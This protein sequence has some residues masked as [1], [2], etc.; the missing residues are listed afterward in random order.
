MGTNKFGRFYGTNGHTWRKRAVKDFEGKIVII[1]AYPQIYRMLIGKTGRKSPV[2][3]KSYDKVFDVR[4][5]KLHI[6]V[7]YNFTCQLISRKI[8]PF[9]VFDGGVPEEK[10]ECI[11]KRDETKRR[12]QKK[13]ES[14]EDENSE[15]AIKQRKKCIKITPD[16]VKDCVEMLQLMGIGYVIA[17]KESDEQ[18]V[19]IYNYFTNPANKYTYVDDVGVTH[20]LDLSNTMAGIVSNDTDI[21]TFGGNKLLKDFSLT[22][23]FTDEITMSDIITVLQN[24]S[25]VI[26]SSNSKPNLRIRLDDFVNFSIL[27]GTNYCQH[28]D[29]NFSHNDVNELYELF[30]LNELNVE[31]T[32]RTIYEQ[33]TRSKNSSI[34]ESDV[35]EITTEIAIQKFM[36]N[37]NKTLR[38]YKTTKVYNP[39]NIDILPRYSRHNIEQLKNLIISCKYHVT[40][41]TDNIEEHDDYTK[42]VSSV[43]R[44][45][46]SVT[47]EIRAFL[48]RVVG[49]TDPKFC[50]FGTYR[51][52][53]YRGKA[54]REIEERSHNECSSY[55]SS[56]TKKRIAYT[57]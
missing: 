29:S 7:L 42:F 38:L 6:Y 34:V 17:P 2:N 49:P 53:Y 39:K 44:Q 19:A 27:M 54:E 57:T 18:L 9:Y 47:T 22:D 21:L 13:L 50:N 11:A 25:N 55:F 36:D 26:T 56:S 43:E 12:A 32:I 41:E 48:L 5:D 15:E 3:V 20:E 31:L 51:K 24:K 52:R 1:D 37:F 30:V 40:K 14:I 45:T 28:T 23:S 8:I 4:D 46:W 33:N 16:M 35:A 10:S